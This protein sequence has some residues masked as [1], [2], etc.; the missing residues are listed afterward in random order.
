MPP[1]PS[2]A[3]ALIAKLGPS[4]GFREL[5]R[6]EVDRTQGFFDRGEALVP[7]LPREVRVDVDLF[8]RGGLGILTKID[9]ID[10]FQKV[11]LR[12]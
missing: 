7:L 1:I 2:Y 6:F 8:I 5:M 3:N 12:H 10:F 11:T 4:P 9:M